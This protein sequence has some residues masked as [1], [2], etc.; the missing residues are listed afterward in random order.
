MA[1]GCD[2]RFDAPQHPPTV[3]KA[4]S[5]PQTKIAARFHRVIFHSLVRQLLATMFKEKYVDS[6][7]VR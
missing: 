5:T 2:I 6:Y 3:P 1:G 7:V 4:T